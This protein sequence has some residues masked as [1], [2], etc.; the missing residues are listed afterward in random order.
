MSYVNPIICDNASL[1]FEDI[2]KLLYTDGYLKTYGELESDW[3][4]L[5][6]GVC[7]WRIGINNDGNFSIDNYSGGTWNNYHEV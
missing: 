2:L 7:L 1:T 4:E 5:S 6:L 3:I